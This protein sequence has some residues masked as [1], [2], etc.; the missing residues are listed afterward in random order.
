ML[1]SSS[2][3]LDSSTRWAYITTLLVTQRGNRP[4]GWALEGRAAQDL[5]NCVEAAVDFQGFLDDRHKN[6]H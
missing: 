6:M 4:G 1:I 5:Q 2:S 3:Y